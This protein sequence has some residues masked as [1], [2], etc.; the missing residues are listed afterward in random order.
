MTVRYRGWLLDLDGTLVRGTRPL[1]GAG[2]FLDAL[3]AA[4]AAFLILTNNATRTAA[5]VAGALTEAGL[6][7][8]PEEVLTSAD[9]LAEVLARRYPG[10]RVLAIGEAGLY[11]PLRARGL[12]VVEAGADPAGPVDAVAV[13]LDRTLTY[14]KLTA[15][16]RALAAGVPFYATNCDLRLPGEDGWL[17]GNG[18]IVE[19]LRVASGRTPR[20]VGKPRYPMLRAALRRLGLP[21]SDVALVGD[22]VLTDIAAG[23]RAGID[24]YL[25]E[26]GVP[27]AKG[28]LRRY[29]PAGRVPNLEAL[30]SLLTGP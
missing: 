1:P 12:R 7:V 6:P 14:G 9:V 21:R 29:P 11:E 17:P 19:L 2:A 18:S 15:A 16:L 22:N 30:R 5:A 3:R 23:R 4:G 26:T 25:V 10:G 27:P 8:R 20:V 13:G 28:A 24:A